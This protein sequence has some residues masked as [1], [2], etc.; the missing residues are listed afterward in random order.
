MEYLREYIL[1]KAIYPLS[2]CFS[3]SLI[4]WLFLG[5]DKSH[6]TELMIHAEKKY[7]LF[8]FLMISLSPPIITYR[9]LGTLYCIPDNYTSFSEA[10]SAVITAITIN[11][12]LP[13]KGG[14]MAKA[15]YV[16]ER[17]GLS[18]AMGSVL[19]ERCVDLALLGSFAIVAM[20]SSMVDIVWA[21]LG[22]IPLVIS[23]GIFLIVLFVPLNRWRY[24]KKLLT[25]LKNLQKVF[26]FW[27]KS[28]KAMI[29]TIG[30]SLLCWLVAFFVLFML[31]RALDPNP[32]Y[33]LIGNA[34]PLAILAG[35]VPLTMSG[36]GTR[37]AVFVLLLTNEF[38]YDKSVLLAF[39]Y[40]VLAYWYLSVIAAFTL[41]VRQLFKKI[42]SH[43]KSQYDNQ[44]L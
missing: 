1:G 42:Y 20:L 38:G 5:I 25:S 21:Y 17:Y 28:P 27:I 15:L 22:C 35:L 10:F 9:W 34:F 31:S 13:A 12:F 41:A 24:P 44:M 36:L 6:A 39:G 18:A 29:M 26:R 32:P 33:S 16:R 4:L 40:T 23:I 7:L 3:I 43:R 8:A 37:D 14:D 2:L 11:S 19:L 30:C